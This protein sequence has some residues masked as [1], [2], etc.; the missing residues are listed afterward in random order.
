[1][2]AATLKSLG[3]GRRDSSSN[4]LIKI[5]DENKDKITVNKD[6]VVSTNFQNE[7]VQE[8]MIRQLRLL[9]KIKVRE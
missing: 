1:M 9:A 7:K 4:R 3:F 6:G 5:L 2:L 8:E